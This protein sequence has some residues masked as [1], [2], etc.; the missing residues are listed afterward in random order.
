MAQS[1]LKSRFLADVNMPNLLQE[2]QRPSVPYI[3]GENGERIL[4]I[5]HLYSGRRRLW[6][7]HHWVDE[8]RSDILDGW[9]LSF[10]T[11]VHQHDGNLIGENFHRILRLASHGVFIGCMGGPLCETYSPARHM[12]K[13]DPSQSISF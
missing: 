12:E 2:M 5:R 3:R 11:A 13:P 10:D 4:I 1:T 7:F 6:D 8:L 9:T